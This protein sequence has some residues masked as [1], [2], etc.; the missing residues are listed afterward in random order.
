VRRAFVVLVA[1]LAGCGASEKDPAPK[2]GVEVR[3]F[4]LRSEAVGE[5]LRP[6]VLAP[7]ARRDGAPL[8]VLLHF[9]GGTPEAM[10]TDELLGELER[11]GDRAPVVLLP[12]GG[13]ASY[14][15]D[16]RDGAW[17]RMVLEEAIPA[18]AKR[19]GADAER[20]SVAGTSMGGFGAL[21][22]ASLRRFCSVSAHSPA[23]F[24][25]RPRRGTPFD[26]AFD[27]DADFARVDPIA[28]ARELPLGTWVDVGNTDPFAPAVRALVRRMRMPRYRS[29]PGGH[30]FAFWREQTPVWLRFHLDRLERC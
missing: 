14:W 11:L 21:H 8:L 10:I 9:Q 2:T 25:R 20:V 29:W 23:V 3:P 6:Y 22:L 4:A 18:A 24:R 27:G 26:D 7:R 30:D 19:F 28:R 13:G 16:R 15:H 17:A 5:T 1:L 12:E